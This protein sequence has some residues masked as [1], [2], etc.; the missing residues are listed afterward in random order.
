MM[1]RRA[2]LDWLRVI[3]FGLLVPHHAAVGF[4]DFGASIYGFANAETGGPLLSLYLL[5][6]HGWRLPTL[7]LIAGMATAFATERGAGAGFL[8]RRLARLLIPAL[9]LGG[10]LNL[11]AALAVDRLTGGAAAAVEVPGLWLPVPVVWAQHLWF[12]YNLA[13]YTLICAPLYALRARIAAARVAAPALLA[14]LA[15]GVIAIAVAAKPWSAAV[16]GD[17]HQLPLY[18]GFYAAG[19]VM[20]ARAEATLGWARRRA[21]WLVATGVALFA[22]EIGMLDATLATSPAFGAALAEG[23]WAARGLGPAWTARTALFSAVETAGAWA[24]GLAALGLAARWA[25]ARGPVL[26]ALSRAVL[27]VYVLHFPLTLVGL[28]LL[29]PLPWGWGWKFAALTAG[30]FAATAALCFLA[31]RAPP[32]WRLLG[33]GAARP[34]PAAAPAQ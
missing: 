8:R 7:F 13:L 23:G 18:F 15:A 27:P 19:Y 26:E 20:G 32:A 5:F 4:A 1:T 25:P 28:A 22:T 2:D 30:V 34:A 17:G 6:G 10:A 3:L 11:L 21:P 24:W 14:A 31:A 29:I 33:G 16:A 12:L 9:T